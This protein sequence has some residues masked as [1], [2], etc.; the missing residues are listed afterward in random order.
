MLA[1]QGSD[2]SSL[3][4]RNSAEEYDEP[5]YL[6]GTPGSEHRRPRS[7]SLTG[8]LAGNSNS[9]RE[10]SNSLNAGNEGFAM[11]VGHPARRGSKRQADGRSGGRSSLYEA[12][13]R[14]T[15]LGLDMS[16]RLLHKFSG[17]LYPNHNY[18]QVYVPGLEHTLSF[19][20]MSLISATH[21]H[22]LVSLEEL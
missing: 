18:T 17:H 1:R 7:A 12:Q 3:W 9:K 2:N 22:G 10:R 11:P 16:L 5:A 14:H 8:G 4:S 15:S 6:Y 19:D 20:G 13:V 21:L